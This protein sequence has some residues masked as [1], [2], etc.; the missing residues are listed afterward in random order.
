MEPEQGMSDLE[1]AAQWIAAAAEG[2]LVISTGAGVSRES[3][4]PTFREAGEGFWQKYSPEQL[5][6]EE[7]FLSD[8]ALVWNWY[9]WRRRMVRQCE[10]NPGH[11]A[12]AE[13]ER[14]LPGTVTVTQNVD[15][16]HQRAGSSRVLELHG[17][18]ERVRCFDFCSVY[19]NWQDGPEQVE[20]PPRCPKCGAYLRPDIVWF[21][22]QLPEQEIDEAFRAAERCRVML[23]VG[24]SGLV[25]PAASLPWVARRCGARVVEVNPQPSEI[26][27]TADILLSGPGGEVLPRLAARVKER[28]ESG[29]TPEME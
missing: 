7:G 22:E 13:L 19:E 6:T 28:L 17:S 18:I 8:P 29:A 2:S 14:C 9:A 1:R 4:I 5:A 15:G 3:G 24:T 23:V 25:Q 10:P 11:Y 21:G 12:L 16:L 26:S 27:Q 20:E